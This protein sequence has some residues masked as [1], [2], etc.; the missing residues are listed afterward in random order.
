MTTALLLLIQPEDILGTISMPQPHD[1]KHLRLRLFVYE[2]VGQWL[3]AA[4]IKEI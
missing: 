4:V 2:I 1:G 3:A